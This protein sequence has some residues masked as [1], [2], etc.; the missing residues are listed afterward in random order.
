MSAPSSR[1]RSALYVPGANVRALEKAR[2]LEADAL[3]LDLEDS[4]A[5]EA[6]AAARERVCELVR[7]RA[8]GVRP[9]ALRINGM[10]T[11]WYDDDL[12]AAASAGPD[13]VLVTKV[14]APEDVVGVERSLQRAG[15]SQTAI[16]AM[17]ETPLAVLRALE[18]ATASERLQVLVVGTN[19]LLAELGAEDVPGRRPLETSLSL[20]L[21]AARA[22]GRLILDGVYN[23]VGDPTGFAAECLDARRLGFDGKTL[24][25]PRQ[26]EPCNSAFSPSERDIRHARRVIDAYDLATKA[27]AGVA[28]VDG[29]LVERLHVESARRVL[30]NAGQA[31]AST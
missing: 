8:F 22:S 31:Q 16:W 14:Q 13:A 27:G 3:I 7:A 29:R 30:T 18:I 10:S 26:I 25:H 11:A 1:L 4:V 17:L 20:C 28:T 19:D 5:P 23:D 21:L 24:I 9:V 2:A 15:A 6:K 12:A